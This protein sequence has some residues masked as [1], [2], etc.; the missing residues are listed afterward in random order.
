VREETAPYLQKRWRELADHPLVGEVRG[1]G[2]LGALELM[3]DKENYV[4]FDKDR[5]VGLT[6]REFCFENNLIMRAVGDTMIISPPLVI[7][8]D[9]IDL[10]IERA[11]KCLDLT[12]KAIG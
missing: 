8:T 2:M 3:Q 7:S 9:E 5:N 11:L 6:C 4:R 10:F 12:Q 1:V